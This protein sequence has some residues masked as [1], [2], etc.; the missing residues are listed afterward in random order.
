[1]REFK[2]RAWIPKEKSMLSDMTY[3]A[4][5][6]ARLNNRNSWKRTDWI[7]MQYTGMQD[8]ENKDIYEGDIITF[9]YPP[10]F[11]RIGT[12]VFRDGCFDVE[13]LHSVHLKDGTIRKW[14]YLKVFVAN[15]GV[16]ILGNI[17]E[18]SNLLEITS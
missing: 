9:R 6:D 2:F 11:K 3:N 7:K 15:G 8:I 12:V 4:L 16:Q 17:Y 18:N 10:S 5:V 13:F 1:M 14:D